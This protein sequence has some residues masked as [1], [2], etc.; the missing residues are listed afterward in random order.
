LLIETLMVAAR[1][2]PFVQPLLLLLLQPLPRCQPART[3]ATAAAAVHPS[4]VCA[5]VYLMNVAASVARRPSV[6][7]LASMMYQFLVTLAASARD[8]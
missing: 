1:A 7:P 8:G 3:A 5:A 4:T 2:A 6:W